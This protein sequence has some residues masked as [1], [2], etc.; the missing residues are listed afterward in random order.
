MADRLLAGPYR[1]IPL[2]DGQTIPFYMLPF[3][4][5]GFCE[6]PETRA[7]LIE[8]V[9][10]GHFTNI[11]IFSHGWNTDWS[12][13][14]RGYEFFQAGFS[15]MRQQHQ[16]PMPANYKPLL[17]GIFWPSAALTFGAEEEGPAFAAGSATEDAGVAQERQEIA[18]LA[19]ALP[20]RQAERFYRL[21]QK[22]RLTQSE[23]LELAQICR[24]FY[25]SKDSEL[26]IN[27]PLSAQEILDV[28]LAFAPT[29]N[30]GA[31]AGSGNDFGGFA[32][33]GS[34][35]GPL[36]AGGNALDMLDPRNIVRLL[37][38]YQMKDRAGTVGANGVGPLLVDVLK[39]SSAAVHLIGHSYGCRVVLSATCAPKQLPRPVESMLLLQPAVN[40][41]CFAE[42]VPDVGKPG[43]YHA[44]LA[45]VRKPI[46]S[47]Y[48]AHDFPLHDTFHLA[49]R[50]ARDLGE[51]IIAAGGEPPSRFAALGGYGPRF[52][53]ESLRPIQ[54]HPQLYDFTGDPPIIGLDATRTI[55]G[56]S[57]VINES[58]FWALYNLI[59]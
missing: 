4:K 58:T 45:R 34:G 9:R 47:T 18:L 27:E 21:T 14:V 10:Q 36:A 46:L 22:E 44:A 5:R 29:L 38:V 51:P 6:A 17:I 35:Q 3:D 30:A 8:A 55:A 31:G 7:Q 56:H 49:L 1:Q 26:Q 25:R 50:R 19:D 53:G 54:D 39:A 40:H 28:W 15:A 13:A 32:V 43:G 2:G 52:C 37:T 20:A 24:V 11:F 12:S 16:L 59:K 48:S 42:Q 57:K 33:G 23:A 41:L